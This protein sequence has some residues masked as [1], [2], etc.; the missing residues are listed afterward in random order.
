MTVESFAIGTHEVTFR[1]WDACV[2]DGGCTYRIDDRSWGRDDRPVISVNWDDAQQYSRWLSA[3]TYNNY[4]LP[5]EAEWEYAARAGTT[6]PYPWGVKASH[7]YANYGKDDCCE[8]LAQGR[9]K[10]ADETAP[11]G[12]FPPNKF[13]LYDMHG[14]IDEWVADC[15]N[16]NYKG[17]PA[18]GRA[19]TAGDCSIA[20]VLRGGSWLDTPEHLR[21]ARRY[22]G[23]S[24]ARFYGN[25]FRVARTL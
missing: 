25:G 3:R 1:E 12:Q 9:D 4:R 17:A 2:T 11:V 5:T 23:S 7:E 22:G 18:D 15:W 13:G 16:D 6:T 24:T 10:W 21:S 19:W 20:R 8:G 14:N